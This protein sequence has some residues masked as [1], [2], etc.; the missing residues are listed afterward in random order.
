MNGSLTTDRITLLALLLAPL[1]TVSAQTSGPERPVKKLIEYGWDVLIPSRCGKTSTTWRRSLSTPVAS[2]PNATIPRKHFL[3]W[4]FPKSPRDRLHCRAGGTPSQG[5]V[6]GSRL[7]PLLFK[8]ELQKLD[9]SNNC[10]AEGFA[11]VEQIPV[12]VTIT[13]ACAARAHAR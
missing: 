7:G 5:V 3:D 2:S 1:G 8:H 10:D 13:S 9:W 12:V 4:L 11:H 6:S